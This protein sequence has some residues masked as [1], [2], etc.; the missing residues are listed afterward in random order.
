VEEVMKLLFEF[1]SFLNEAENDVKQLKKLNM[2]A[3][4]DRDPKAFN[5]LTTDERERLSSSGPKFSAATCVSSISTGIE[6]SL[7]ILSAIQSGE[8][9][10]I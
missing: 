7:E 10:T 2:G 8:I 4:Y 9:P 3:L 5:D 6:N 1:I